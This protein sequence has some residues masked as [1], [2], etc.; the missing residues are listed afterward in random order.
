MFRFRTILMQM[1]EER[2]AG[3][4][5]TTNRSQPRGKPCDYPV[6]S[7]PAS[8]E[9]NLLSIGEASPEV[10]R[11]LEFEKRI[12]VSYVK[13]GSPSFC[14]PRPNIHCEFRVW[15]EVPVL[16]A[17]SRAGPLVTRLKAATAGKVKLA[18]LNAALFF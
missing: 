3:G 15:V 6:F 7:S 16:D 17:L 5:H 8:A 2:L 18:S 13:A 1:E 14:A 4:Q 10:N 9:C 12:V 11:D